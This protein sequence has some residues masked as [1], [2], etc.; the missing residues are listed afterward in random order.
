[1]GSE[2]HRSEQANRLWAPRNRR[3]AKKN[4]SGKKNVIGE[5]RLEP[6][7]EDRLEPQEKERLGAQPTPV[8]VNEILDDTSTPTKTF[9]SISTLAQVRIRSKIPAI[10]TQ[11][12]AITTMLACY[13]LFRPLGRAPHQ[14]P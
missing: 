7:W 11:I 5:G 9:R 6:S 14:S 4:V 10:Q 1:M 8:Q 12:M 3:S 2:H 13:K